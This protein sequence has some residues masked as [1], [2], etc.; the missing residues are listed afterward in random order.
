MTDP[1]PPSPALPE[2]PQKVEPPAKV[3]WHAKS[4]WIAIG[5]AIAVISLTVTIAAWLFPQSTDSAP[6]ASPS[7][8]ADSRP[9]F[10]TTVAVNQATCD[11]ATSYHVVPPA[12]VASVQPYSN[13]RNDPAFKNA[14]D[15]IYTDVVVTLQGKSGVATILQG[16]TVHVT[17][18]E[19]PAGAAFRNGEPECGSI[20]PAFF[21][22]NLDHDDP[23][24]ASLP[25]RHGDPP[26]PFPFTI[27]DSD[28]EVF[29]I[30]GVTHTCDCRWYVDIEWSSAGTTGT[31]TVDDHG[32][33]FRTVGTDGIQVTSVTEDLTSWTPAK[34]P[35]YSPMD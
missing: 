25:G 16:I 33:P 12:L 26:R 9:P 2:Q 4:W 21:G 24:A 6:T 8:L 23:Q 11:G 35:P 30:Y 17:S 7:R 19:K 3:P 28:P 14:P 5:G 15:G 1:A 10:T 13:V 18:R 32:Q 31:M 34:Y 27:S 22:I 29:H 20:S